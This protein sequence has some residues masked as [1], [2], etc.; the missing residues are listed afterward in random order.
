M[1]NGEEE[2][3][4]EEKDR[5]QMAMGRDDVKDGWRDGGSGGEGGC[6]LSCPAGCCWCS[7]QQDGN[8]CRIQSKEQISYL[9]STFFLSQKLEEPGFYFLISLFPD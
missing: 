6:W 7:W 1:A 5:G 3:Q 2:E 9:L 8:R 4:V